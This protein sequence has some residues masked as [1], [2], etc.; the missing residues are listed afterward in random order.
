M[1]FSER[2]KGVPKPPSIAPEKASSAALVRPGNS[3]LNSL[4]IWWHQGWLPALLLVAA[5]L[6]VYQPA[7]HGEF[8]WDDDSWTW[9]I[10]RLLRDFSGV[11]GDVD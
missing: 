10:S 2:L 3:T 11:A 5:T 1:R 9:K 6:A 4:A 7:L 8:V